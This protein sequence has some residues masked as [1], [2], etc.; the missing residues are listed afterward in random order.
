MI[1][2]NTESFMEQ[3]ISQCFRR[4]SRN[5]F[6]GVTLPVDQAFSQTQAWRN[7]FYTRSSP[8]IHH[9]FVLRGQLFLQQSRVGCYIK[10]SHGLGSRHN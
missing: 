2:V 7:L 8:D 3:G 4:H 9:D 6:R 10:A 1:I 5:I